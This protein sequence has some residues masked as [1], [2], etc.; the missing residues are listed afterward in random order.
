VEGQAFE[1]ASGAK[2]LHKIKEKIIL[3]I[4]VL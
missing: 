2:P 3:Q 4:W 1:V